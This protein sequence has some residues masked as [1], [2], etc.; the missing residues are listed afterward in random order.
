MEKKLKKVA[1]EA[2][3]KL[4]C[5]DLEKVVGGVKTVPDAEITPVEPKTE[6][7]AVNQPI[8]VDDPKTPAS[9]NGDITLPE[10]P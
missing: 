5:S 10:I 8:K 1:E 9:T 2:T 3:K 7:Q 4:K 6:V